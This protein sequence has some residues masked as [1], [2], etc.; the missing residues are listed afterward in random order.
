MDTNN[1]G[2]TGSEYLGGSG[3]LS[4]LSESVN[5]LD[6]LNAMEKS[7]NEQ[8]RVLSI[9]FKN[10]I[11]NESVLFWC[12]CHILLIHHTHPT[13]RTLP[14]EEP[15]EVRT[16]QGAQLGPQVSPQPVTITTTQAV[17]VVREIMLRMAIMEPAEPTTTAYRNFPVI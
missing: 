6:P 8:V 11:C 3:P 9:L 7:L 4:H 2:F 16:P 15:Q 13:R 5:S 14:E 17:A 1:M 10:G 12:R